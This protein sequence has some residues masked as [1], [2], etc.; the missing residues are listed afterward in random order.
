MPFGQAPAVS[1]MSAAA[2]AAAAAPPPPAFSNKL[3]LCAI[4]RAPNGSLAVG[5]VDST[6]TPP[7][8]YY[9]DV[10]DSED[11][12]TVLSADIDQ[13]IATLEKDD[14]QIK[15]KM[16]NVPTVP[17][18][19]PA[20]APEVPTVLAQT[21][22]PVSEPLRSGVIH[23]AANGA[24]RSPPVNLALSIA[25]VNRRREEIT[26]IREAGGDVSSYITMLREREA[27]AKEAKAEA[28]QTARAQIQALAQK[29]TA[30]QMAASEHAINFSLVEQ[31]A[32][33]VSDIQLS[34]EEE[35]IL[36]DKGLLP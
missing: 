5:F 22:P 9:L 15:L 1:A 19:K 27:A 14:V 6:P 12:F 36:Q 33:P 3:T 4:N 24:K 7:H 31:G 17:S 30:E 2:A 23:S 32:N 11:G 18:A 35:K 25:A 28:E 16:G 8:N 29:L 20:P 34:T 10:G 26:K 13:E 21:T